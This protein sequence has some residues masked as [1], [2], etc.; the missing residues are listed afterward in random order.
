MLNICAHFFRLVTWT[1]WGLRLSGDSC[2]WTYSE[3]SEGDQL[4]FKIM[5]RPKRTVPLSPV[6]SPKTIQRFVCLES[7]SIMWLGFVIFSFIFLIN[8]A[9]SKCFF[10][11]FILKGHLHFFNMTKSQLM[12][13]TIFVAQILCNK[14]GVIITAYCCAIVNQKVLV[15]ASLRSYCP[16]LNA[17]LIWNMPICCPLAH[18][19]N[20]K[21]LSQ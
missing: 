8:S 21:W 1:S 19:Y 14:K 9:Y 2:S 3:V 16:W 6:Y 20:V 18:R 4:R 5:I 7:I 13:C 17:S 12:G 15:L 10:C 11:F